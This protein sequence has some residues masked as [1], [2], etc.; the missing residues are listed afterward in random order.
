MNEDTLYKMWFLKKDLSP[1]T[2]KCYKE[3]M[4]HFLKYNNITLT[5]FYNEFKKIDTITNSTIEFMILDY[6]DELK[7][8]YSNNSILTIKTCIQSFCTVNNFEFPQI[9]IKKQGLLKNYRRNLKKEEIQQL[10]QNTTVRNK[11]VV[12]L[13]A[14]SGMASNEVRHITLQQLV[15]MINDELHTNYTDIFEVMDNKDVILSERECYPFILER[16]KCNHIYTTFIATET[17]D[18]IIKYLLS[19][20]D[21]KINE[22]PFVFRKRDN[23]P[24]GVSTQ[25]GI[26]KY[27]S[28]YNN[29]DKSREKGSQHLFTP[30]HLR[31][32]FYSTVLNHA[33]VIYA[34]LWTGHKLDSIRGAYTR[35]DDSMQE[36]YL[37]CLPYLSLSEKDALTCKQL[38]EYTML[39]EKQK[40]IERSY[41][42]LEKIALLKNL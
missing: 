1:Q 38:E 12:S 11:A 6:L 27:L 10:I 3:H 21:T 26:Q 2:R 23:S 9:H 28:N 39:K 20:N 32:Y 41:E 24:F 16:I 34:D 30:H 15:N 29:F 33:G 36:K 31:R 18:L 13:S 17:L 7:K 42:L 19:L 22:T 14:L 4:Q 40:E 8:K 5:E 35:V 25:N 37:K